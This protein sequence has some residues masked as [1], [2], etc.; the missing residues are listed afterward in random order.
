MD[1]G[2]LKWPSDDVVD[3]IVVLW[4]IFMKIEEDE[5]LKK[6]FY[7]SPSRQML[8]QLA[9]RVLVDEYS[10]Y[11]RRSCPNCATLGWNIVKKYSQ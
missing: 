9:E 11:W 7:C 1:R 2:S 10:E 6:L 8:I 3:S 4:K 5:V